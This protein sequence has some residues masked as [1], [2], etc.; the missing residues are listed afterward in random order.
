MT[1]KSSAL[2][3]FFDKQKKANIESLIST[4]FDNSKK[5][6]RKKPHEVGILINGNVQNSVDASKKNTLAM[7][8]QSVSNTLAIREQS[9]SNTLAIRE[10]SVR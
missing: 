2:D 7:R 4:N 3:K 6:N 10:Q 8:E 1:I 5:K 9:V